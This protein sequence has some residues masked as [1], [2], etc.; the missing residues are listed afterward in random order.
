M[1]VKFRSDVKFE[2]AIHLSIHWCQ[3][4]DS[5]Y[6]TLSDIATYVNTAAIFLNGGCECRVSPNIP[7]LKLRYP[8]MYALSLMWMFYLKLFMKYGK[9]SFFIFDGSYFEYCKKWWKHQ[10]LRLLPSKFLNSMV[11]S[12]SVPNFSFYPA[13]KMYGLFW[14]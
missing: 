2:I 8:G 5:T 10:H 9:A 4:N 3:N 12:S 13:V 6:P 14:H 1:N 7:L 11:S